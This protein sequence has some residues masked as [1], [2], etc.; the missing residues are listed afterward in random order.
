[1][2]QA[3][4]V[5]VDVG[6][7]NG[8]SVAAALDYAFDRIVSLEP[9]P[10][11]VLQLQKRFEAEIAAGKVQIVPFGL[12]DSCGS[13]Q[14]YGDNT[15]GGSSI[16]SGKFQG[17]VSA[18]TI[19]LLDW[20]TLVARQ[21]LSRADLWIKINA[22]GAEVDIIRSLI[23]SGARPK[24]LVIYFDIVKA[25]FG[26]W[27][28]WAAMSAMKRAGLDFTLAE[29]VL[30]KHGPRTRLHNWFSAFPELRNPA[31]A[32]SPAPLSKIVRMHYLDLMS[33]LGIRLTL[34]KSRR[35]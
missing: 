9:D 35:R 16:V 33:A 29:Q 3:E 11:M 31:I 20:P 7:H 25:P 5:F 6:G 24:G 4:K 15:L 8:P 18:R 27:K 10:E 12:S 28:K 30:V 21:D 22:E 19:N 34:F 32:S 2:S 14:L 26:A 13:A 1:M 17:H 23:S